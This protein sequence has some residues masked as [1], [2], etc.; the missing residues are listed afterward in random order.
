MYRLWAF[1]D[2]RETVAAVN[3]VKKDLEHGKKPVATLAA[4]Y[5]PAIELKTLV[6]AHGFNDLKTAVVLT[7]RESPD[8]LDKKWAHVNLKRS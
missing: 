5:E 7:A 4:N 1:P 3:H 2:T 6:Q 8:T